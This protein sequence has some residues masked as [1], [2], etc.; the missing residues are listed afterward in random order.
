[1]F[2]LTIAKAAASAS[3]MTRRGRLATDEL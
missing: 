3:I 1:V 2:L